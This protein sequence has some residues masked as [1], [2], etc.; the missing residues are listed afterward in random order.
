MM[1]SLVM[2]KKSVSTRAIVNMLVMVFTLASIIIIFATYL[3]PL[4][5]REKWSLYIFDLFVTSMLAV[6]FYSRIKDS[7]DRLRY[8]VSHWYE[9]PAMIPLI[10]YGFIDSSALIQTTIGTTR[11]I[12]LFR[13]V[14][15]YNLTLM[16]KGSEIVLL[17]SLAV[18]TVVFGGFG[19]YIMESPSSQANITNLN[20]AI[21]WAVETITTVAYGEFYPVTPGGRLISIVLMLSAIGILWTVVAMVTSKLVERRMKS[22]KV[23]IVEETK[24]LI[25]DKIDDIEKLNEPELDSLIHMIRSLNNNRS[26]QK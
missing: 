20:D 21:W 17:S 14:R 2:N 22:A 23:G 16:V 11:Y 15:L 4:S 19:I 6:D 7:K 5:E 18:V 8:I 13:L 3:Y 24:S 1:I 26:P 10:V 9:F 12:A 25:K